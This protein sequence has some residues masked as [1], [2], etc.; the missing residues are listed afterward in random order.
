M[1]IT[2]EGILGVSEEDVLIYQ[3]RCE[4]HTLSRT[5]VISSLPLA[6]TKHSQVR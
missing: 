5:T 1:D 3:P 2:V 6:K 4:R